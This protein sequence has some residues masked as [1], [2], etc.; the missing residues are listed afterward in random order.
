MRRRLVLLLMLLPLL[1]GCWDARELNALAMV[2]AVGIDKLESGRFEVT[3]QVAR[4]GN[5]SGGG[6]GAG[7]AGGDSVYTAS[8]DGD[9]IF[10][11]IR[12]LAQFTSRRIMWAHNNVVVVGE[13][14]AQET[15]RPVVDFFTRNQ[16]LRMRT[17]VV[18]ARG[19]SA[20]SVVAAKTGL[21]NIPANSIS[22]L[23]RYADLPGES[24]Q[25]DMNDL[26]DDVMN[27]DLHPVL[28]A[29]S[30]EER[31]VP[32]A[33]ASMEHGQGLQVAL[34]GTAI[35]RGTRLVGYMDR[36]AGRGLLWLRGE[37]GN[38][39]VSIPCPDGDGGIAVEFRSPR[40]RL[41]PGFQEGLPAVWLAIET[42]GWISERD[43]PT[44]ALNT[45]A[46]KQR[47]EEQIEQ[48]IR[49]DV[50]EALSFMQEEVKVDAANY[51]RHFHV[52]YPEWWRANRSRWDELFLQVKTEVAVEIDV[53]KPGIYTRPMLPQ[54][55]GKAE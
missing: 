28:S 20:R 46:L 14:L 45:L 44:A 42:N 29:V 17:W 39:V 51:G 5:R 37:M 18:V 23:M 40:A 54:F 31:A 19:S 16:E 36:D 24:V 52:A 21:E 9:T 11:A 30:L 53:L 2:M 55:P 6:G 35:F 41:K 12:N 25:T 33:N 49:Q 4:P 32:S 13:S 38:A 47:L 8:A 50:L 34:R 3:I 27:P 43:C 1:S 10:A 22:A 7:S 48:A 15:I 26:A